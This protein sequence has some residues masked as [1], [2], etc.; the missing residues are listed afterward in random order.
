VCK[1][2][3]HTITLFVFR[4]ER[5]APGTVPLG[6]LRVDERVKRGF[7][8]VTWR[9]G[10]LGYSLVSDVSRAELETLAQRIAD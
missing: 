10:D 7:D 6:R 5:L 1:R 8:V 4:A 9:D 2:R 3:F